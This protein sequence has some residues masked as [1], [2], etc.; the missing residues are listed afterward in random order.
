M[1][2]ITIKKEK[3]EHLYHDKLFSSRAIA[4]MCNCS[5]GV[6]L[7]N[8]RKY[9]FPVR[10]PK[11]KIKIPKKELEEFYTE[12]KL[13]TY[14]IAKLYNCDPKTIYHKLKELGIR[15]RPHKKIEI[16][17]IKLKNLYFNKSLSLVTIGKLYNCNQVS[18][19]NKMKKYGFSR[20][21]TWETNEKH[22]KYNFSGNPLEKSYL[23]GFRAGD[24]GVRQTSKRTG[25]IHVGCNSTKSAQ[26]QLIKNLFKNYGPIWI[27]KPNNKGVQSIDTLLNSSF[28]FLLPKKDKIHK[29]ILED[30]NCFSTYLA[31]Y[32]DAEGN[33][34]IYDGRARFRIG[35]YDIGILKDI[36]NKLIKQ[37]IRAI[38]RLESPAGVIDK[39]GVIHRGNFWRITIS[40][41]N[42]LLSLFKLI[43]IY[44][45]HSDRIKAMEKAIKNIKERNQT[46]R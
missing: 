32:T 9:H 11:K 27:S 1:K 15:I 38:L 7:R 44:L 25:N 5:Q 18:I 45:R 12:R 14:K 2:E 19:L 26:I 39:R 21:K 31:G 34:G 33:I 36:T 43:G 3:L 40:E 16:S 20:R 24:L 8:L 13:S 28:S 23:L 41:K 37:G 17:E 4:K 29:W 22:P 42:S 10:D 35:S 30:K 46:Y 6:I